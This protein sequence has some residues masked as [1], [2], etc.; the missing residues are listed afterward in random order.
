LIQKSLATLLL[1]LFATGTAGT[2]GGAPKG[3]PG[4][5]GRSKLDRYLQQQVES[6]IP[7]DAPV[8]VI[9]T[10]RKGA[11]ESVKSAVA[12]S[13]AIVHEHKSID[14]V[15][16]DVPAGRLRSLAQ[17]DD[18]IAVSLDAPVRAG[19]DTVGSLADNTLLATLGLKEKADVGHDVVVAV[20]DSGIVNNSQIP[21]VGFYDFVNSGGAKVKQYDDYGHGTHVA[22]MIKNKDDKPDGRYRSVAH[23][24]KVLGLK[25]LAGDGS[26]YT[27][28]VI[29]A[30]E[31]A[32]ANKE[33][34]KIAVI[35]LSLGH[36]IYE[37]AAT[38]PLVQAVERAV[39]AGIVVVV[40][41]G[42]E[43]MNRETGEV[44][45]A[46]I[47]SPGNAPSAITVGAVDSRNT[48]TRSDDEIA[49]FS[50][51]GPT[52]YDGY[53]K[54]DVVAPGRRVVSFMAQDG[55]LCRHYPQW[56]AVADTRAYMALSGTSMAA[57]VATGVVADI[58]DASRH[59]S[60][61]ESPSPN[62]VKAILEFTAITL[63]NVDVLSQGAGSINAA[64]AIELADAIDTREPTSSPWLEVGVTPSTTL[65]NGE[66]LDWAQHIVWGDH[67][68][69]GNYVYVNEAAWALHVVWGNHIVWGDHVV[70]GNAYDSVVWGTTQV[71]GT[72]VVWGNSVIGYDA[73]GSLLYG[74][75]ID[76]RNVS[77]DHVVWG[78]LDSRLEAL[79]GFS[80]LRSPLF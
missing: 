31:F 17:R 50:S 28:T 78:A 65:S 52:W 64:G 25:V 1:V 68:V 77:A 38:D 39:D 47:T 60:G 70:W 33:K 67:V 63:P 71:W 58:I 32:I 75:Q 73:N 27:S 69:W 66:T 19:A 23:G 18:V 5:V 3:T 76:W 74:D 42:N 72:H 22:G 62:L 26:G 2:N 45:Y 57:A 49:P 46:G 41:A 51:R 24:S 21:V 54:P 43:G 79:D 16:A 20:L 37:P 35:N 29:D 8:R 15:T 56:C 7:A 13:G 10:A 48:V 34:L 44:G 11:N 80:T 59:A 40:A 53:A 4:H 30:I 9:V 55:S 36:P 12:G 14:A 61:G 6:R